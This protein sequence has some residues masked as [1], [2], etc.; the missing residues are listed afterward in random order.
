GAF[1]GGGTIVAVVIGVA[2]V[3]LV[4]W[5]VR[6]A[7]KPL[8][9]LPT[10]LLL[11]GAVGNI[12]DRIRDGAVTDFIKLPAWPAFNVADVAITFGVLSLLYVLESGGDDGG[13]DSK[14]V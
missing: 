2:L 10:G 9:W 1:A 14:R 12:F 13:A 5:F 8:A 7:D 4:L 6:H 3:A 11:G